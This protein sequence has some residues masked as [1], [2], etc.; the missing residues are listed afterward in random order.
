MIAG[1]PDPAPPADEAGEALSVVAAEALGGLAVME[2]VPQADD[3][4]GIV[5]LDGRR[6]PRQR[7][8]RV[9]GRQQAAAGGEARPLFEMKVGDRQEAAR[10]P[11]QRPGQ[12]GAKI[13]AVE[14]D[15]DRRGTHSGSCGAGSSPSASSTSA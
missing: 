8:R 15:G 11:E 4:L 10:R 13:G 9:V 14:A 1:D 2:A 7:R 6:Q 3:G 12:V 5:A